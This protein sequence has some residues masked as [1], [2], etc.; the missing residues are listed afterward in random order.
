MCKKSELY[1]SKVKRMA[2]NERLFY[3]FFNFSG[4][5]IYDLEHH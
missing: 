2:V 5:Q 4:K 3:A 1:S